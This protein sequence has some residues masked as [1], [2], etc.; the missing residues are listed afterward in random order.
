MEKASGFWFG[1]TTIEKRSATL[2][3]IIITILLIICYAVPGFAVDPV[4]I[5]ESL[6]IKNIRNN[7]EYFLNE[8][9]SLTIDDVLSLQK[10]GKIN[11]LR[12]N[13]ADISLGFVRTA[14]WVRLSAVNTSKKDI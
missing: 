14:V 8:S 10:S 7:I 5:D 2:P 4:T 3:L 9:R 6:R 11:W 13:T 12:P 1:T